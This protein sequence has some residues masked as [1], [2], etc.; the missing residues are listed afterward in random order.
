MLKKDV[1]ISTP[2]GAIELPRFEVPS[3]KT[4]KLDERRKEAIKQTIGADAATIFSLIPYV[5]AL[6]SEQ[7][8][9]LHMREVYKLLTSEEW[10]QYIEEERR[11]PTNIIPLMAALV[12]TDLRR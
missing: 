7:I 1:K 5:G 10:S 11:Y 9:A 12:K 2:F 3:L 4:P 6:I 8:G